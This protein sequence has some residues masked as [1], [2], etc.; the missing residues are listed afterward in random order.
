VVTATEEKGGSDKGKTC[1]LPGAAPLAVSTK[2][3]EA[4]G[5]D[6][7]SVFI[8]CNEPKSLGGIH[9]PESGIHINPEKG[10]AVVA[11]HRFL[12]DPEFDGYAQ[13]YHMCPNHHVYKHTFMEKT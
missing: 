11:V 10:T 1:R 8:F 13:E 5:K 7:A 4:S 9:F 6:L 12:D 2:R 3:F